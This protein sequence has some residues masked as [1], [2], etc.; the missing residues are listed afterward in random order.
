MRELVT[1]LGTNIGPKFDISKLKYD[2]IIIMTDADIDGAN[3]TSLLCAFFLKFMPELVSAGKIYKAI[4]PLYKLEGD[5]FVKDKRAYKELI[6]EKISKCV[7]IYTP[8]GEKL[9][10]EEVKALL[11]LNRTYFETLTKAS[12]EL[13]CEPIFLET[14]ICNDQNPNLEKKLREKY[15]EVT[16]DKE[17]DLVTGVVEG[18]LQSIII[19]NKSYYKKTDDIRTL[20]FDINKGFIKYRIVE[21]DKKYGDIERGLLSLGEFFKLCQKFNSSLNIEIRYKGLGELP[22]ADL[23]ETT[24]NPNNRNLIQM[25]V[26]DMQRALEVFEMLHGNDDGNKEMMKNFRIEREELDN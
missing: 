21:I 11:V 26:Q 1:I 18:K 20:I 6:E 13:S 4:P 14:I 25:T 10:K 16:F 24:M 7:K 2:K 19:N 15:K 23:W 22:P 9:T 3:I 17:N 12:D 8:D 5:V